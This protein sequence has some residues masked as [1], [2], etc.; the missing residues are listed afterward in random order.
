MLSKEEL[1]QEIVEELRSIN[2]IL[3]N[4][5]HDALIDLSGQMAGGDLVIDVV[6]KAV[7]QIVAAI[8][9]KEEA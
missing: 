7:D 6:H 9:S 1:L 2:Y 3:D 4:S 8:K 5:I